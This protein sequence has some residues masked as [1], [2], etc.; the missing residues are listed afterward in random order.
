MI[1]RDVAVNN[2]VSPLESGDEKGFLDPMKNSQMTGLDPDLDRQVLPLFWP[3]L[4]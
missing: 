1:G 3:K 4:E 2:G